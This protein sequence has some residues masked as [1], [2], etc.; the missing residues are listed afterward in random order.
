MTVCGV[1][2]HAASPTPNH[3]TMNTENNPTAT[4]GRS[5]IIIGCGPGGYQ[6]AA[7]AAANGFNVTTFEKAQP[8]GT[9][10]N[11]GCIP[12]KAYC[13]VASTLL[14]QRKLADLG[15]TPSA[16]PSTAISFP[17][18]HAHKEAVVAQLRQGIETLMAAPGI[19]YVKG[20]ARLKDA[21]TVECDGHLYAADNIIIASG[22]HSAMPPIEGIGNPRVVTS[23]GLL[24]METLPKRL[25][26]IGA[27]VI[28]ME[29]ASAFAAFGAEVTV[30]EFMKECLPPMDQ[31]LAKRLRK[32]LEKRGVKF[33]LGAAAKS[34]T[35]TTQPDPCAQVTFCQKNKELTIEADTVLVATGRHPN[36]EG[37]GLEAAG[38]AYDRHGITV[39]ENLETTAKGIY[40]I[41]DV[42]GRL[43]LAHAAEQ[44][45][46]Q[47]VERL[48]G[49]GTATC[50][51]DV[52]VPSAV[53]TV[54][55]LAGVGPLEAQL[56]EQGATFEVHK[57]FYRAN[58]KAVAMDATDGL[59]KILTDEG[60][61]IVACHALGAHAADIVQEATALIQLGAT[62][63]DLHHIVHIHPT[64]GELLVS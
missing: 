10:L 37:L 58:G 38:V 4:P 11:R 17:A 55:E 32:L 33:H 26:I 46:R 45:G 36:T 43:M 28:G 20:E 12:T 29:M 13:H 16:H 56:K 62:I 1:P 9:C 24:A 57:S 61:R 40:A 14:E 15:L 44:Q 53:F 54:P 22:S 7:F 51:S 3:I 35:E 25:A 19:T 27:G 59:V 34:I 50:P 8:G 21:R 63:G 30:I 42:N 31:D 6:T 60:G 2:W 49:K 23:T 39:D 48:M 5:L 47:V 64:L 18:V 41:G 52:P